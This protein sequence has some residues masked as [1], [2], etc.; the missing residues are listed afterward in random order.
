MHLDGDMRLFLTEAQWIIVKDMCALLK[1]FMIAQWLL[2]GESYV[3]ISLIPYML[4][5]I[6]NGLM[7]ANVD[8]MSLHQ[9]VSVITLMLVKFNEEFGTGE[10]NT[11][12]M[13]YIVE[14]TRWRLKGLP[15][16]V[17]IAMCLDPQTKSAAGIPLADRE[18]IWV[19][20]FNDLVDVALQKSPPPAPAAPAPAPVPP[21]QAPAQGR[22][23][24]NNIGYSNDV[25]VFFCMLEENV[26]KHGHVDVDDEDDLQ[27][28]IDAYDVPFNLIG[29][30][31]ENWNHKTVGEMVRTEIEMYKSATGLKLT[32]TETGK[33]LNP[34]DWWRA[35]QS[36]IPYLAK[37][38]IKYLGMPANSAPSER[39]FSTTGLTISKERACL[40]SSHANELVFLHDN[41]PVLDKYHSSMH[42]AG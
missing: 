10:Q 18:V 6:R 19:Y 25:V 34:L 14:G 17:M 27:E 4:Y 2:E 8:P 40:E 32:N 37:L 26:I 42:H 5:T 3:K 1:L 15:D 41:G 29:D 33:F 31:V 11:V 7:V 28:L 24:N 22:N 9:V 16:I 13:D 23:S 35:R 39:V 36:D 12:A 20:V 38:S 21:V 30:A